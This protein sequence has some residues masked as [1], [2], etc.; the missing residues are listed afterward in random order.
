MSDR[1]LG[2]GGAERQPTYLA[3]QLNGK[4]YEVQVWTY[5]PNDFY[6]NVLLDAGVKW[7]YL[8]DAQSKVRRILI[9]KVTSYKNIIHL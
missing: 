5:Y 7:R 6:A 3:S 9:H 2:S 4:G 8:A 1:I